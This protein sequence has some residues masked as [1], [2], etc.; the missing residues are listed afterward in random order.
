MSKPGGF[1]GGQNAGE[2]NRTK[3]AS[4]AQARARLRFSELRSGGLTAAERKLSVM[5]W[6]FVFYFIL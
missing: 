3:G 4:N 1:A 5:R 2:E 6:F